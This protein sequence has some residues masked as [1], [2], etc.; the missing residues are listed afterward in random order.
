VS[1]LL[2]R[3]IGASR[4]FELLLTGRVIDAAEADR[5]GLVS[6]VVPD[7][8]LLAAALDVARAITA[9]SPFGVRMT[10]D[11]MWSQLETGSMAAGIAMENSTQIATS[12]SE[13]QREALAAFLAKRPAEFT[14]R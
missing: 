8:E 12:F 6:R 1:W 14:D 2:P 3:L 5:I 13:D 9:N 11:V 10:K 4:A 7:G